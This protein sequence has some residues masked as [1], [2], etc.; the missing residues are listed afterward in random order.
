[1]DVVVSTS[2]IN[3]HSIQPGTESVFRERVSQVSQKAAANFSLPTIV[4]A[5]IDHLL[6]LAPIMT[7]MDNANPSIKGSSYAYSKGFA[8]YL[9]YH[10]KIKSCT[11][12]H[13]NTILLHKQL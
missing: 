3:Q 11:I 9:S 7:N 2:A 1:M 8:S 5:K 4:F 10:E 13:K 12:P 6:R